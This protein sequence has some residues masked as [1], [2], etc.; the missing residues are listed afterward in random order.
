MRLHRIAGRLH[1]IAGRL[2]RVAGRLRR[3]AGR[4]RRVAGRLRGNGFSREFSAVEG[5]AGCR[6]APSD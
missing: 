4:L 6:G 5:V 2:R 3:V 1:R